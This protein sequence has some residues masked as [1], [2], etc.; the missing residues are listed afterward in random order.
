LYKTA[1]Q[2]CHLSEEERMW[3]CFVGSCIHFKFSLA[4]LMWGQGGAGLSLKGFGDVLDNRL[5]KQ[6]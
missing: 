5:T 1:R 4:W 3:I 6:T 2:H